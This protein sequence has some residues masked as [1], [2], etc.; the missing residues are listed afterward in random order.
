[1]TV[2][3][4]ELHHLAQL[5]YLDTET[6]DLSKLTEEINSIIDFVEQLNTID[7]NAIAP[8][9]HPMDLHQRLR[10]DEISEN[11][12]LAQLAEIAPLFEEGVYL[13]PKVIDSGK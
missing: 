5:A 11:D 4:N 8:L 1:M 13:V 6:E 10:T 7:T 12:C 3:T 2:S 9:F